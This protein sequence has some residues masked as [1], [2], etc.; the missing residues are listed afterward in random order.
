[1]MGDVRQHEA[2]PQASPPLQ[3]RLRPV[4]IALMVLALELGAYLIIRLSGG[5]PNAF[6]HLIYAGVVLAA[7]AFGAPGGLVAGLVGGILLG[8]LAEVTGVPN[9]GE[10]AWLTRAVAYA[11]VGILTG[12]LFDRA[13]TSIRA[14][15]E[16]AARVAERERDGMVALARGAEAKDTDT[17]DHIRRVQS[18]AEQLALA[19]GLGTEA[20]SA[21]GWA[22]MLHDVG[23]LHVPDRIL[24][25]PSPLS[26]AEWEVMRQH[27]V[28][29]ERILADGEGFALARQIA[30]WHH[31]NFDG[32]GY[33]DQIAGS[34][35]PLE[36]RIVRLADA[37]D[38]MTHD[39]PYRGA[40][41]IEDA[42]AE[43]ARGAGRAFDPELARVFVEIVRR[44]PRDFSVE[45]LRG[46]GR[47]PTVAAG[48]AA[49]AEHRPAW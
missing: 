31:E 24:L 8:P 22:G 26:K 32:S 16:T 38:A 1:M 23:K 3:E 34:A 9:D 14:W 27:T 48:R 45:S 40:L 7:Y 44:Q 42:L 37:F 19:A 6:G 43:L 18:T 46:L 20:A 21:I 17:G 28:W 11:G 47:R 36:V 10:R 30:R 39:R 25:K 15:R 41:L 12:L 33:P 49:T 2:N 4:A 13:R 5:L 29:G 35:I